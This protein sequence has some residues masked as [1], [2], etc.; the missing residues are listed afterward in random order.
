MF[1]TLLIVTFLVA[2]AVSYFVV[3]LFDKPIGAILGRIITHDIASAW[4]KYVKF[5]AYVVGISGGVRIYQLE[6]YIS[7][8]YNNMEILHLNSERWTLEVYGTVIGT[9]QSIAWMFL[10]FF[11]VA[12]VAYV[13]VHI[14]ELK[15]AYTP[16]KPKQD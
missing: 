10:V 12:L 13:I 8:P 9:L 6:R 1:F 7:A 4:H 3:R 5:A 2:V 15:N 16:E 11:V 14:F